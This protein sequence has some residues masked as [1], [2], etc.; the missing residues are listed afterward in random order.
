MLCEKTRLYDK[1]MLVGD[2]LLSD[3][4]AFQMMFKNTRVVITLVV[5]MLL[6]D[7]GNYGIIF[8]S[9]CVC[10]IRISSHY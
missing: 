3:F 4:G 6:R 7:F 9:M 5:I 10:Y 1:Q 8:T 2:H